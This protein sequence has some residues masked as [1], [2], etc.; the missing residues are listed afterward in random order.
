MSLDTPLIAT[1]AVGL[2]LALL[3][4]WGAGAG[5]MFGLGLSVA[6]TVVLLERLNLPA[7]RLVITA[8]PDAFEAGHIEEA[9]RKANPQVRIITRVKSEEAV[10]YRRGPGADHALTGEAQ[11]ARGMLEA[12]APAGTG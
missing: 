11:L 8:I 12:M 1:I 9:A 10:Q 2:G 5:F 7:A 6:S 4:G 3:L